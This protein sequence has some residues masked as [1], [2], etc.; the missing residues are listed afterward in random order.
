MTKTYRVALVA[1]ACL[2]ASAVAS[3]GGDI[4]TAVT[5]E[6]FQCAST[7]GWQFVIVRS[8]HSYG[9]PDTNAPV[10]LAAA[11][12]GGIQYRDIYHFPCLSVDPFQQ[13]SDDLNAVGAG[14]FGTMWFD[15]EVNPSTGCGWADHMTNCNFL[16]A[17]IQAGSSLG[18]TMGVYSSSYEWNIVMGN[19]SVGAEANLPLWYAHYDSS[20]SYN[21]FSVFGGWHQPS[22]KQY[23]DADTTA[24]KCGFGADGDWYPN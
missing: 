7:Y 18:V 6:Q 20:Q 23:N 12:A 22:I 2:V 21:D 13:V 9:A 15:I 24:T 17:L 8:Y 14:N 1:F 10:A 16:Q 4:A 3:I 11:K 5:K 19:C